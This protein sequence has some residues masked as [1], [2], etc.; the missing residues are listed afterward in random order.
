MASKRKARLMGSAGLAG[1]RLLASITT[2]SKDRVAILEV[3]SGRGC[4]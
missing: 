4:A 2:G 1:G 3:D